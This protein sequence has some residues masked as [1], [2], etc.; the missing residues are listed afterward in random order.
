M[1]LCGNPLPWV[2]RL[3]HLGNMVMC[4][5]L[6]NKIYNC[7]FTG[8]QT[9][10]LFSQ[11]A[12]RFYSTYNRSVKV[13]ADLPYATHRYLIEPVSGVQHM[14][15]TLIR[16]FLNFINKIK[17]SP[18]AVLRH[19]YSIAKSD[20]RTT[21]GANLRNILLQTS[22]SSVDDLQP[23]VVKQLKYMEIKA[24]DMWR[25]PIIKEVMDIRSG[26][27][28]PPDGWTREELEDILHLACTE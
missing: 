26:D 14:T 24:R 3:L 18:K 21:T 6:L 5:M 15:I 22:L 20:V 2:D 28:E 4:R 8:C 11:G 19:L 7:H 17:Q 16:N 27:I 23:G 12:E 25:I 13:M 9:W 1:M 10:D